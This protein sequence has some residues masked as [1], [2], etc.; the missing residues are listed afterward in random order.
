M[1]PSPSYL[2]REY[3]AGATVSGL[4]TDNDF[5]HRFLMQ[6][7]VDSVAAFQCQSGKAHAETKHTPHVSTDMRVLNPDVGL[8]F[9]RIKFIVEMLTARSTT[10]KVQRKLYPV[11]TSV[12]KWAARPHGNMPLYPVDSHLSSA[13]FSSSRWG[14][15]SLHL[16]NVTA[17][18]SR[19]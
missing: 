4:L 12:G 8:A 5:A 16:G 6:R 15:F 17:P 14:L 11:R 18:Q 19:G 10:Y 3:G 2:S 7:E 13:T 1:N 9:C